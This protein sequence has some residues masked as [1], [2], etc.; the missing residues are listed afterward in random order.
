MVFTEGTSHKGKGGKRG[1]RACLT[2]RLRQVNGGS[3]IGPMLPPPSA[4]KTRGHTPG[5]ADRA[6]RGRGLLPCPGS[7]AAS[8][9]QSP[10]IAA[11]VDEGVQR[12]ALRRVQSEPSFFC[13]SGSGVVELGAMGAHPDELAVWGED[14]KCQ[15]GVTEDAPAT[16]T[17]SHPAILHARQAEHRRP[18]L[19]DVPDGTMLH[20][21][22]HLDAGELGRLECVGRGVCWPDSRERGLGKSLAEE[23]AAKKVIGGHFATRAG[24]AVRRP[25]ES[26]KLT[27]DR[28]ERSGYSARLSG[29]WR[30]TVLV[31][32][33]HAACGGVV[34]VM[35][36]TGSGRLG[37]DAADKQHVAVPTQLRGGTLPPISQVSAGVNHTLMLTGEPG[38]AGQ[39]FTCGY[40]FCNSA[41][42]HEQD[43]PAHN[44][45]REAAGS[46]RP[47]PV[48]VPF[49]TRI[50]AIS[51]G[52]MH[53]AAVGQAGELFTWGFGRFGV[54]G[55][56]N[57]E[58]RLSPARVHGIPPISNVS[59][60]GLFT[61]IVSR[62]GALYTFGTGYIG[63][64]CR[65]FELTAP[66]RVEM[67]PPSA[68]SGGQPHE[69]EQV[70]CGKDHIA[71][72]TVRGALLSFGMGRD[73]RLGHDSTST[74]RTPRCAG[75][76][77]FLCG[78][79]D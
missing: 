30:H 52:P 41:S 37:F 33:A 66:Q 35:G 39:L 11:S 69:I 20:I 57:T 70:S 42:A 3:M 9:P 15:F 56:G 59:C 68:S 64:G 5:P 28:M 78:C 49:A 16:S 1:R 51:A 19:T 43:A 18:S 71:A 26:W 54:L 53:S 14:I 27:L 36:H 50:T 23:A 40:G 8:P 65:S 21:L 25:G 76:S 45:A 55:G 46:T 60:G 13:L 75:V 67:P 32:Q 2:L 58:S 34:T 12:G 44:A 31:D 62:Q 4:L 63:H 7:P 17:P 29:G 73:G 74:E 10:E 72:V 24:I 79:V 47:V 6:H 61:A 48:A 22:M 77:I 38:P